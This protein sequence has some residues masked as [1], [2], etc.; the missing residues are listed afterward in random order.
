MNYGI[1]QYGPSMKGALEILR[2]YFKIRAAGNHIHHVNAEDTL[3]KRE[4][5]DLVW[6][7]LRRLEGRP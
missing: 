4:V 5:T 2:D 7:L 1:V 6:G 3:S